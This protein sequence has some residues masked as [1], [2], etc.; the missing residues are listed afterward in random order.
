MG[1][2]KDVRDQAEVA[3]PA[4][5]ESTPSPAGDSGESQAPTSGT[6]PAEVINAEPA[7]TETTQ[8]HLPL[9]ESPKL[10]GAAADASIGSGAPAE[11][12]ADASATA[13][14]PAGGA[15]RFALLAASIA[16][17]AAIGSFAG[18]LGAAGVARLLPNSSAPVVASANRGNAAQL[19]AELN[20]LKANVE[21]ATRNANAQFAKIAD[22]IERSERAQADPT[23]KITRIAEAVD[24]IEKHSTGSLETTGSIAAPASAAAAAAPKSTDRVL[25]GWVVHQVVNGRALVESRYGNLFEIN[26]G[27][28]LPGVGRVEQIKRQDGHWLV[29]TARGVIE[30]YH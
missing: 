3:P 15:S 7:A 24:R 1:K 2:R 20:A 8:N 5:G 12:A 28:F 10:D 4:A 16:A 19:A 27:G 17:A 22:R 30:G 25:E 23:A 6:T 9:I 14:A 21:A 26:A 11:P 18:S 13:E 29:V